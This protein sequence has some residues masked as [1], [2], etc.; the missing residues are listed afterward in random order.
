MVIRSLEGELDLICSTRQEADC[1]LDRYRISQT[2]T[3]LMKNGKDPNPVVN[4]YTKLTPDDNQYK[5][6]L[7]MLS[8]RI[9]HWTMTRLGRRDYW[10]LMIRS[11]ILLRMT[12]LL[13]RRSLGWSVSPDWFS[14]RWMTKLEC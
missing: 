8:P 13:L 3:L 10:T 1:I 9:D 4:P 2:M 6:P 7:R 11:V 12:K 14:K 5:S